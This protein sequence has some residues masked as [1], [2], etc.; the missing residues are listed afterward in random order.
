MNKTA[1]GADDFSRFS[2]RSRERKMRQQRQQ[3]KELLPCAY[4]GTFIPSETALTAGSA[5]YCSDLCREEHAS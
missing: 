2:R 4:C 3:A 1:A 5:I